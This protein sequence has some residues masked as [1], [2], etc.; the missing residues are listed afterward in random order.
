MD[1]S[2]SGPPVSGGPAR[3]VLDGTRQVVILSPFLVASNGYVGGIGSTFIGPKYVGEK[4]SND[5]GSLAAGLFF[6]GHQSVSTFKNWN[7]PGTSFAGHDPCP[8]TGT[9][10]EVAAPADCDEFFCSIPRFS[11]SLAV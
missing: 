8:R 7:P 4:G 3:L 5:R 2:R 1:G 10:D 11:V 6:S 9:G